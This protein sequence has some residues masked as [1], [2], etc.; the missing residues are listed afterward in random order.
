LE[1]KLETWCATLKPPGPADRQNAE[2]Q[3]FFDAHVNPKTVITTPA[4][5]PQADRRL[6]QH[7]APQNQIP[8]NNYP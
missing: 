7:P 1:Q 5:Q 8:T 6:F 4:T 3:K 2:D